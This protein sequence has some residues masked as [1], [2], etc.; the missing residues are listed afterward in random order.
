M[1]FF[2][3]LV[4]VRAALV[5]G[6]R[7]SPFTWN[8]PPYCTDHYR[9]GHMT[10]GVHHAIRVFMARLVRPKSHSLLIGVKHGRI[11]HMMKKVHRAMLGK[12]D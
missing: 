7:I 3:R 2:E 10:K 9:I 11:G 8:L 12:H 1:F 4:N 5:Y 6:G